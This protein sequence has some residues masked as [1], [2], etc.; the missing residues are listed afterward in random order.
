MF[1][2]LG[3]RGLSATYVIFSAI[4]S[5]IGLIAFYTIALEPLQTFKDEI[6]GRMDQHTMIIENVWLIFEVAGVAVV[7]VLLLWVVL[8][9]QED[10]RRE[11]RARVPRRR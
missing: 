11:Q 4:G 8:A 10:E 7:L 6:L 5:L 9:M 2:D 1:K 3:E